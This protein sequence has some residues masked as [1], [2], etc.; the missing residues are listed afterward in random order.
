SNRKETMIRYVILLAS[1]VLPSGISIA[2]DLNYSN[3]SND[4][5]TVTMTKRKLIIDTDGVSDDI[6][7][8]SLAMQHPDVEIIA[9]TTTHGCV[10]ATQ[11]AANV[12]RAQRANGIEKK[13]PIYKGA[14]SQLI[15]NDVTNELASDESFFFG[16]DGLGDQPKAFPEV[17][18]SDFSCWESEHAAQALIRLTKEHKDVTLV[19]IGPLTNLALA[20]KLDDNFKSQPAR[21]VIMGGNYY[22]MGNV[23]SQTSAEF[24]F[25]GDPEAASIVLAEIGSPITV[26]PW[27]AFALDGKKHEKEVDFHAHLSFGTPL[28]DF[29]STATSVSRKMMAKANRQYA[30]CDEIAVMTAIAPE[31]VI[32]ESERLRV[33]VELAGKFTRGQVMVDWLAHRW[34]HDAN[35]ERGVDR[36]RRLITFVTAYDVQ[37]VD[38]LIRETV[39]KSRK[40]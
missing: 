26:V 25:H 24:N 37:Y 6:R 33:K 39:L 11:A 5:P 31:K 9:F 35:N 13:I 30:Y 20:L 8:I 34:E 19:A 4:T 10:S 38:S 12:A 15:K 14:S 23:N 36:T 21:V 28:A 7:A 27:E 1:T 2:P 16:K 17:L 22:G 18:E 40:Q 32:K 29:F 3:P